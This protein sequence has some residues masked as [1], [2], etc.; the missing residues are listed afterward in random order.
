MKLTLLALSTISFLFFSCIND[1]SHSEITP[2][3]SWSDFKYTKN[4][5]GTEKEITKLTNPYRIKVI[6]KANILIVLEAY[7][8]DYFASVYSLDSLKFLQHLI[9]NG[10]G[11]NEQLSPSS[12][13]YVEKENRIYVF[14]EILQ[15][16]YY[17]SVDSLS[18]SGIADGYIVNEHFKSPGKTNVRKLINPIIIAN[19][20]TIVSNASNIVDEKIHLL[21]FYDAE[22]KF[23]KGTGVPPNVQKKFPFFTYGEIYR[24][25]INFI[26][27]DRLLYSFQNTDV[28]SVFDTTGNLI[29]SRQ[30]PDNYQPDF[31]LIDVPGGKTLLPGRN[32]RLCY[33][34]TVC[35]FNNNYLA[36]Y[37]GNLISARQENSS[38]LLSFSKNLVPQT[39][40][41]LDKKI[42]DF[43]IDTSSG[44]LYGISDSKTPKIVI[45]KL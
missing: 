45:F 8:K 32:S 15:R 10:S 44:L 11:V 16:F 42:F 17:Y 24:G 13:Q 20:N 40:Y 6:S 21:D 33:M 1:K 39:H 7:P 2:K 34:P 36:L 43:D 41:Q 37:S 18:M 35:W 30:G 9:K 12:M 5:S 27:H 19:S 26:S 14:D 3:F 23:Q 4:L 38:N 28:L 22:Y 29:V 31:L 25:K